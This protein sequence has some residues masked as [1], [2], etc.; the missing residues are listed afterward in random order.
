MGYL[1]L[2]Q[3]PNR[4]LGEHPIQSTTID[5]N[6]WCTYPKMVPLV[7]THGHFLFSA[8]GADAKGLGA[9]SLTGGFLRRND[10]LRG[11][12]RGVSNLGKHKFGS[13]TG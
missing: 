3:N 10:R 8:S 9:A 1:A 13:L 11:P 5:Q 7:L 12:P 4:T 2:G 6:R